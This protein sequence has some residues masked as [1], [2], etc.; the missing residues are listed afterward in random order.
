LKN[1][2]RERD[3]FHDLLVGDAMNSPSKVS[4]EHMPDQITTALFLLGVQVF[5]GLLNKALQT[6]WQYLPQEQF[7]TACFAVVSALFLYGPQPAG[8]GRPSVQRPDW[9]PAL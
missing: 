6:D 2:L 5:L 7:K 8:C 4:I 9:S 1:P 3:V